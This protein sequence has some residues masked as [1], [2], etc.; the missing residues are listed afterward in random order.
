MLPNKLTDFFDKP[1]WINRILFYATIF[2]SI[3]LVF[4]AIFGIFNLIFPNFTF[5]NNA[6]DYDNERY[7]LSA[8]VQSLAATIALVIT[9]SLVA[10]QL[11]AQSYS[12]RVIDVYKRNPDMWILL[13]IYIFTI[14]YGLG[15]TKIVGLGILGNY[16]EGT[17][18]VAYFMGFFAFICLVPYML[19]TLDL[20]KPSTVITLLAEEITKEKM[21]NAASNENDSVTENDPV[22]P[23]IDITNSALLRND[24]E[25]VRNCLTAIK[26]ST[27]LIFEKDKEGKLTHHILQ[28]V[29]RFGIL[30][31]NRK[32]EDSAISAI[33]ILG[34]MGTKAAEQKLEEA[35]STAASALRK[36][37]TKAVEQELEE[38]ASTTAD[39]LGKIG[40]KAA[41]KKMSMLTQH[42]VL[43]L[44]IVGTAALCKKELKWVQM[45]VAGAIGEIG[46]EA[47]EQ[48]LIYGQYTAM[49]ALG[50]MGSIAVEQKLEGLAQYTLKPLA[51]IGTKTK[52]EKNAMHA[53]GLLEYMGTKAAE[54][55]LGEYTI[56]QAEEGLKKLLESANNYQWDDVSR[57]STEA[58]EKIKNIQVESKKS[59]EVH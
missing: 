39:V 1:A 45:E 41:E 49:Q 54:N 43:E 15:L 10:V 28:H 57:I 55:K 6:I 52:Y 18:F 14:F 58:L 9:L 17:I 48:K 34:E 31:T 27:V 3:A 16:M 56:I 12:A 24:Y 11:A 29:A 42:L 25:T 8:L 13:C 38:A 7:L 23:I 50:K 53:A 40:T 4:I 46:A 19:K 36:V 33:G 20:L 26:K 22:Q 21:L 2:A 59:D 5:P 30:A 51:E 35:S 44:D 32:N 37:G 47:A